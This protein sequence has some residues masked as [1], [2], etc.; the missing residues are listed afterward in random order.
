MSAVGFEIDVNS[1]SDGLINTFNIIMHKVRE[2][3]SLHAK[4]DAV[5]RMDMTHAEAKKIIDEDN[6][7]SH[8]FDMRYKLLAIPFN[9]VSIKMAKMNIENA[10]VIFIV[11]WL[12][13]NFIDDDKATKHIEREIKLF[14][15]SVGLPESTLID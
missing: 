11:I 7:K 14:R 3:Y 10:G 4:K 5:K 8:C 13:S 9:N 1:G 6:L 2:F 15:E 12:L